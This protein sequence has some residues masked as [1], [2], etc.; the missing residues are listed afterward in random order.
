MVFTYSGNHFSLVFSVTYDATGVPN[1]FKFSTSDPNAV[2]AQ[3]KQVVPQP[4]QPPPQDWTSTPGWM[5]AGMIMTVFG[6]GL[7]LLLAFL[8]KVKKIQQDRNDKASAES[9]KALGKHA[10]RLRVML[11]ASA[12][13]VGTLSSELEDGDFQ[14]TNHQD[15]VE[16]AIEAQVNGDMDQQHDVDT[17]NVEVIR[18][19]A[20]N[21]L[22]YSLLEAYKE[23]KGAQILQS[24]DKFNQVLGEDGKARVV[25]KVIEARLQRNNIYSNPQNLDWFKDTV[26]AFVLK[27]QTDT[28][29]DQVTAAEAARDMAQRDFTA[30]QAEHQRVVQE[31]E[32]FM[33]A[34]G[35]NP[36][37]MTP[38]EY[39]AHLDELRETITRLDGAAEQAQKEVLTHEKDVQ[40]EQNKKDEL[41]KDREA[42][43]N[44]RAESA[45]EAFHGPE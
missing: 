33:A 31:R 8:Q 40:S 35:K 43:E 4:P 11:E 32:T 45:G 29:G 36:D 10:N 14:V 42:A 15:E 30:A 5:Q 21:A 26:Q 17:P 19:N 2:Q 3:G 28:A 37:N 16:Q 34:H 1:P 44:R 22:K 18:A 25:N 9:L 39:K 38:A 12:E 23:A 41:E 7:P 24:F 13:A 20:E 27:F 6:G